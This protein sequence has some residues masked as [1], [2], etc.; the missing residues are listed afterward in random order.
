MGTT[1]SVVVVSFSFVAE[2][3]MNSSLGASAGADVKVGEDADLKEELPE[4]EK[5]R[6]GLKFGSM[7]TLGTS[8]W[9]KASA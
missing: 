6:K 3:Q 9:E 1:L 5:E 4:E 7:E 2:D 8:M